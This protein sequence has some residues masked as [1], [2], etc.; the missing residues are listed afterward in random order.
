MV[1]LTWDPAEKVDKFWI[2]K[3][4]CFC[5]FLF[6]F[7]HILYNFYWCFSLV[8][9]QRGVKLKDRVFNNGRIRSGAGFMMLF[10]SNIIF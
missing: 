8:I 5:S 6:S 3:F 9:I 4:G 7:Y 1:R 2:I 10:Y